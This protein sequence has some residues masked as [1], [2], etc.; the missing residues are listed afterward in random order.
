MI[1]APIPV[2]PSVGRSHYQISTLSVSLD[3]NR[4]SVDV[5][6]FPKAPTAFILRFFQCIF[7]KVYFSKFN[8]SNVYFLMHLLALQF[9]LVP[10]GNVDSGSL[11]NERSALQCIDKTTEKQKP[12][13]NAKI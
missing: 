12:I 1:Q 4:A 3:R 10:T 2:S 6:C 9:Y 11:V 5:I 13:G 7:S 8:F